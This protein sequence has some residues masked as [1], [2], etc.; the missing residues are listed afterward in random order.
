M[1]LRR[2]SEGVVVSTAHTSTNRQDAA[3]HTVVKME[4]KTAFLKENDFC[5][6]TNA[7]LPACEFLIQLRQNFFL[8]VS[9]AVASDAC[10]SL[11]VDDVNPVAF[12]SPGRLFMQKTKINRCSERADTGIL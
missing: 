11:R 8:P 1:S 10:G 5:S 4:K 9:Q 7:E 6:V 3:L 2:G 12:F